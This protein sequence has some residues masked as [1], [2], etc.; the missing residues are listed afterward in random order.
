MGETRKVTV[1]LPEELLR[2]ARQATGQGITA[3]IRRGL[4]LVAASR[5]YDGLQR[6]RGKVRFSIDVEGLREERG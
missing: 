6:R 5:A 3:T 2:S 4:R 1:L